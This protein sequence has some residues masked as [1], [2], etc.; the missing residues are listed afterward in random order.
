VEGDGGRPEKEK[1]EG[2][3]ETGW[4]EEEKVNRR[5]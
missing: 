1:K 4:E 5:R 2:T 3:Q